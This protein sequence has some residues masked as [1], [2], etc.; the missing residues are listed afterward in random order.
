MYKSLNSSVQNI[1]ATVFLSLYEKQNYIDNRL[2]FFKLLIV[3]LLFDIRD[4]FV[5]D[6]TESW[7]VLADSTALTVLQKNPC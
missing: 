5:G 3:L 6:L 2:T 1:K 7:S 4:L